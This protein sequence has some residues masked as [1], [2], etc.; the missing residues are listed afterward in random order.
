MVYLDVNLDWPRYLLDRS[1]AL[2]SDRRRQSC[3]SRQAVRRGRHI[4]LLLGLPS[5]DESSPR[6]TSYVLAPANDLL[7]PLADA[8]TDGIAARLL[9]TPG[10]F[11]GL[12]CFGLAAN[13]IIQ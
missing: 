11:A 8:L 3:Q 5:T 9:P 7:N 2:R 4:R 13:Q 10:A 12:G 1:S 6:Q